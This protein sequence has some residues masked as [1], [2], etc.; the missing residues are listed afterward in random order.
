MAIPDAYTPNND[1]LERFANLGNAD[2]PRRY[3]WWWRWLNF[4]W[5]KPASEGCRFLEARLPPDWRNTGTACH[6]TDRKTDSDHLEVRDDLLHE[7]G[8]S[9]EQFLSKFRKQT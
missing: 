3:C 2:C 6:R 4:H 9:L 7:T 8:L 5:D 1:D